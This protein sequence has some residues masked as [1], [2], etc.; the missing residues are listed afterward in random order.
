MMHAG[1][2]NKN[3]YINPRIEGD[4]ISFLSVDGGFGHVGI[5]NK[6]PPIKMIKIIKKLRIYIKLT[7]EINTVAVQLPISKI[8]CP[9]SG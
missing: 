4:F 7:P 9:R 8:D 1:N 5:K 2:I 3:L 6:K